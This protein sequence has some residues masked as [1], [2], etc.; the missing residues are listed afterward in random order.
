[1]PAPPAKT[2]DLEKEA[3]TI[4]EKMDQEDD[5]IG[6]TAEMPLA[7][8]TPIDV[9]ANL[10]ARNDDDMADADAT[11]V[12]EEITQEMAA[13]DNTVEMPANKKDTKAN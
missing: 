3:A 10:P 7:T 2:Q 11:G 9:T 8:V 5:A 12:N 13:D 4:A 1:M 6:I